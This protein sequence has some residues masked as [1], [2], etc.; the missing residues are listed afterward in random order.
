MPKITDHTPGPW[1]ICQTSQ[2]EGTIVSIGTGKKGWLGLADCYGDTMEEA[3]ANA[4][5]IAAAPDLLA[6]LKDIWSAWHEKDEIVR[7]ASLIMSLTSGANAIAK[8]EGRG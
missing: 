5:L 8:A 2:D 6:A 1:I 7:S 3:L 4:S